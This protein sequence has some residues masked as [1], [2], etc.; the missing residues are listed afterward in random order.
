VAKISEQRSFTLKRGTCRC[1]IAGDRF[2]QRDYTVHALVNGFID[3]AHAAVP[4]F[5]HDAITVLQSGVW[6]KAL[7]SEKNPSPPS[8][9]GYHPALRD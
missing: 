2:L 1:I 3:R 7:L 9:S 6:G 4:K 8:R 5:A